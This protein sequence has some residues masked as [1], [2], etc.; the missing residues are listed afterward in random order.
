MR[1]LDKPIEDKEKQQML[2][3]L[4][5]NICRIC[6][7]NDPLEIIRMLGFAIDRISLLAQHR[8]LEIKE[9]QVNK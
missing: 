4:Q 6:V 2:D 3:L 1:L 7:G 9:E 8:L 5:G